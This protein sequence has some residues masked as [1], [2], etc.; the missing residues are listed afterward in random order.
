MH[1]QLNWLDPFL[2]SGVAYGN[3]SCEISVQG[4]VALD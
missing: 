1:K 2:Q 3:I 4:S